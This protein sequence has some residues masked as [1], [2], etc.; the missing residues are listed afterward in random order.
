MALHKLPECNSLHVE[1]TGD[2]YQHKNMITASEYDLSSAE[3]NRGA[4][5]VIDFLKMV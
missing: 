2:L 3:L 4:F 5:N 1:G